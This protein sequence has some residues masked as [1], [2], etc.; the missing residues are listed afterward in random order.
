V[1][2]QNEAQEEVPGLPQNATAAQKF[3][4]GLRQAMKAKNQSK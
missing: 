1:G 4:F 3:G 2:P